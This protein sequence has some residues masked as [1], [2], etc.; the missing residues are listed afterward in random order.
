MCS[1]WK[2]SI[3]FGLVHIPAAVSSTTKGE[4]FSL[5]QKG[6]SE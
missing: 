4:K 5:K 6:G 3:R 1:V 2:D